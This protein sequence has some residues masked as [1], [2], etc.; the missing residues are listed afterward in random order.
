LVCNEGLITDTGQAGM[1][2]GFGLG[3]RRCPICMTIISNSR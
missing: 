1:D 2:A 3:V